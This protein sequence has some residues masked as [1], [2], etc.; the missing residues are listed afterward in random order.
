MIR[1]FAQLC[2]KD[3]YQEI[4]MKILIVSA[5]RFEIS[6][7]LEQM[8]LIADTGGKLVNCKYREMEIDFLITGAGMVVTAFYAGKILNDSY[9]VAFNIGICGSFNRN[10][11]IGDIVNVYEDCFSELGAEDGAEFITLQELNLEGVTTIINNKYGSLNSVIEMLP[12]VNGITVNKVHGNENSIEKVFQKF[13]PMVE[14]MEGAAFMFAC[15][16]EDIPYA[17]IR[18]VSNYVE[19]RN[20]EAW[21]IPLAIENLNKKVIEVLNNLNNN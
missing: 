9:D 6:P 15:E 14:S 1:I 17:Q 18:A 5:T 4:Y 7:L 13:H 10:I 19:K 3:V 2:P 12:K 11:N 20:K 8:E 21:N 16:I